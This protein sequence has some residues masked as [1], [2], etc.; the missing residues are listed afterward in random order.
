MTDNEITIKALKELLEVM[1]CEG[2]LQRTSTISHAIDLINR[3][4]AE[5]ERLNFVRTRDAERYK[6]KTSNQAHTNSI[7]IDL[8]SS[9]IKEVKELEEKLKIV[10]AENEELN[11]KYAWK[12]KEYMNYRKKHSLLKA[13]AYKE[14]AEKLKNEFHEYRKQ[15]KE[16]A[17]FD[18]ACAMLI[19]KQ[20]VDNLLK[21]MVGDNNE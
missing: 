18:G 5:N 11:K 21:E 3:L 1:L 13:E 10:N 15:Y 8:H 9:A 14:F 19:A 4:Q 6:E 7:L 16:V 12:H 2:D 20:G 17:N